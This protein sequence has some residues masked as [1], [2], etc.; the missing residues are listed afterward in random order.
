M[1]GEV[2]L[3]TQT[4]WQ[5]QTNLPTWDAHFSFLR[6]EAY[7][8]QARELAAAIREQRAPRYGA[9]EALHAVALV[10]AAHLAARERRWVAPSEI[11]EAA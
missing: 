5:T 11:L 1:Y 8:A 3:S 2:R 9:E 7:A 10:E 4:G 6:M